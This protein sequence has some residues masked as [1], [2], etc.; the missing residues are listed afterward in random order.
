M[1]GWTTRAS[2][3]AFPSAFDDAQML[4]P[5]TDVSMSVCRVGSMGRLGHIL[6]TMMPAVEDPQAVRDKAFKRCHVEP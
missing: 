3:S 4:N 5:A 1:L 2:R 6:K